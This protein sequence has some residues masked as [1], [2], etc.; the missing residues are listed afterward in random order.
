MP[1]P[2]DRIASGDTNSRIFSVRT[3]I[4]VQIISISF[5]HQSG[6]TIRLRVFVGERRSRVCSLG[7]ERVVETGKGRG[8]EAQ[9]ARDSRKKPVL[10]VETAHRQMPAL[11]RSLSLPPRLGLFAEQ[12]LP[13]FTRGHYRNQL[14]HKIIEPIHAH[15]TSRV[16]RTSAVT[17]ESNLAAASED[18]P[19]RTC[20]GMKQQ[21]VGRAL[22]ISPPI[23][24]ASLRS[25]ASRLSGAAA[26]PST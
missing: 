21:I 4:I 12:P 6:R 5:L 22:A 2:D 13:V 7:R 15:T 3:P 8:E 10:R 20:E 17:L 1:R 24:C 25:P 16:Q 11:H 26:P 9:P 19:R 14:I 18:P 23:T